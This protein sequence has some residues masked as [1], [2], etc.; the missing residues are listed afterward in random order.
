MNVTRLFRLLGYAVFPALSALL[1]LPIVTSAIPAALR[2]G[3]LHPLLGTIGAAFL[4]GLIAAPGY[5]FAAFR[6]K[7]LAALETAGRLWIR[8]SLVLA[9]TAS[10]VGFAGTVLA[11]WPLAIL[12][13]VTVVLCVKLSYRSIRIWRHPAPT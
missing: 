12:P 9:L 5:I 8:A 1:A 4:A 13:F 11:F 3:R 2:Q 6:E 10:L 7:D